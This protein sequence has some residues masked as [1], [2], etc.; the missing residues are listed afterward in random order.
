MKSQ[1]QNK[2]KAFDRLVNSNLFQIWLKKKMSKEMI[3]ENMK[4]YVEKWTEPWFLA[5]ETNKNG[6]WIKEDIN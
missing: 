3:D 2:L 4:N 1:Y 5:I 6:K